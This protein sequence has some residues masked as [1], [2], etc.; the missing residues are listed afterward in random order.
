[1]ADTQIIQP[2]HLLNHSGKRPEGTTGTIFLAGIL[3]GG[4]YLLYRHY[5]P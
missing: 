2:L 1:M 3:L 5:L 4:G